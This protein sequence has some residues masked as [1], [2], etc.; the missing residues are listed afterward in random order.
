[1]IRLPGV[2]YT[3]IERD[4]L[5][6]VWLKVAALGFVAAYGALMATQYAVPVLAA[7]LGA[8]LLGISLANWRI[9]YLI[10][11][12][13]L[14]YSGVAAIILYPNTGAAA[15]VKDVALVLPVYFGFI[16]YLAR[17]KRALNPTGASTWYLALL[18]V[19]VL[20]QAFN[21]S[22]PDFLVPLVGIRVWLLYIPLVYLTAHFVWFE[23]R[24]LETILRV[25]VATSLP[26]A[27]FGIL[28]ALLLTVGLDNLAY[29]AYG[30]AAASIT[31]DF[32]A[33]EIGTGTVRRV[34]STLPFAGQ[35]FGFTLGAIAFSYALLRLPRPQRRPSRFALVA[36]CVSILAALTSGSRGA[37]FVVPTLLLLAALFEG[38]RFHRFVGQGV[39]VV[40]GLAAAT[41]SFGVSAVDLLTHLAETAAFETQFL[42]ID[43]L[44]RALPFAVMGLGTGADT[45]AARYVLDG[46]R[47]VV[48]S[49]GNVWFENWY[50]K[51]LV[52][53]GIVGLIA[54]A[55][56]VAGIVRLARFTLRSGTGGSA[57]GND[58]VRSVAAP[59]AAF[60]LLELLYNL[61]GG[62]VD[63][64]PI[65][66]EFWIVLGMLLAWVPANRVPNERTNLSR[67]T[68]NPSHAL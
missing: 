38:L 45:N 54:V 17:T 22:L 33:F 62:G 65:N 15:L 63:I 28:Q 9:S 37:F 55:G 21:P 18:A 24:G 30:Q 56:L 47:L 1:V 3:G 61:K 25:L 57:P 5:K 13:Y 50:L 14:P 10:L 36:L 41:A 49:F 42:V 44:G 7:S 11:L 34:A 68:K 16:A 31:Q 51:A 59:L 64:D 40:G 60:L 27:A 2:S 4:A 43:G 19:V 6:N 46:G 35:Y 23:E 52:E 26:V 39:L 66:V 48:N 53:L 12:A 58:R 32:A 8:V 29:A 20:A 67:S